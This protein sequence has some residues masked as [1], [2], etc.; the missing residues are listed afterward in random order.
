MAL[1]T[2]PGLAHAQAV[3]GAQLEIGPA[4]SDQV[5]YYTTLGGQQIPANY[6]GAIGS[7]NSVFYP[8]SLAVGGSNAVSNQCALA[9]GLGNHIG[10]SWPWGGYA[11]FAV[12]VS[13]SMFGDYS[14]AVGTSNQLAGSDYDWRGSSSSLV[15]GSYNF[16]GGNA[17]FIVGQN[18]YVCGDSDNG[19][20]QSTAVVGVGLISNWSHSL[21]V[22][23]YNDSSISPLSGL[24]FA[25]G[26]GTDSTHRSNALEVYADGKI[27]MPRQGDILMGEFG[28]PGE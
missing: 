20:I 3:S 28:N 10:G 15:V 8:W 2:I 24:L 17:T 4:G 25:I 1:A 21:I 7:G 22:G 5:R 9:V 14:A 16:T 18:N 19:Y 12:G 27:V 6:S 11:S 26:N 13:N 23:Q